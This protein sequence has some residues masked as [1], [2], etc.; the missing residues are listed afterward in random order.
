MN[1]SDINRGGAVRFSFSLGALASSICN[2]LGCLWGIALFGNKFLII[3]K[4]KK[5]D[6][7]RSTQSVQ[8]IND[9]APT[10]CVIGLLYVYF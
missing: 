9:T 1:I 3:Q 7:R 10:N 4:K 8:N 2:L 6:I 5:K